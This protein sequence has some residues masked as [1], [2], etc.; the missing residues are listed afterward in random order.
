MRPPK[1]NEM[2]TPQWDSKT[3]RRIIN[4][5]RAITGLVLPNRTT[6]RNSAGRDFVDFG[7]RPYQ[8]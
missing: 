3:G 6:K 5:N 4:V 7:F 1:M 2:M 8:F